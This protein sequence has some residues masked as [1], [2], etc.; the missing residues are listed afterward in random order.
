MSV[1]LWTLGNRRRRRRRSRSG[2]AAIL[3]LFDTEKEGIPLA[4]AGW[5]FFFPSWAQQMAVARLQFQLILQ[6]RRE[7]ETSIPKLIDLRGESC[8]VVCWEVTWCWWL[9]TSHA[10]R[11]EKFRRRSVNSEIL[12]LC[13][14]KIRVRKSWRRKEKKKKS[15]WPS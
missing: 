12:Y 10:S 2:V 14:E 6:R 9:L 13:P 15:E 3:F 8:M 4:V 1:A 5:L 11:S 7:K